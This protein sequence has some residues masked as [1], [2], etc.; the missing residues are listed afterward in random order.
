[1]DYTLTPNSS[2]TASLSFD[3]SNDLLVNV[4][5]SLTIVKGGWWFDP[6]FGLTKRSRMKN[7]PATA[8]L[9]AGDCRSALQWLLDNGRATS[10]T[11]TPQAVDNKATW[12]RML[13][14]VIATDGRTVTY[15][16]FIEVV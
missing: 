9:L 14:S 2:G 16:K 8:S 6:A 3:K 10:I 7:T 4:Y 1:M 15:D 5:L 12:L 11:V 13:C